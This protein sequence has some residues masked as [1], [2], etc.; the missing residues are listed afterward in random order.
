MAARGVLMVEPIGFASNPETKRD[1]AFQLAAAEGWRESV[2][3]R[4]R[5]EF[6]ELRDVLIERN[7]EVVSFAA[8]RDGSPDATFPNNWFSTHREGRVVLYPLKAENRRRERR[9]EIVAYLNARYDEII[10]LSAAEEEDRF[11]EGTG[12][13]VIDDRERLVY[14][15][16]SSRTHSDLVHEWCRLFDFKPVLFQSHDREGRAVYHTNVLLCLGSDFAVICLEAVDPPSRD[17]LHARLG[18]SGRELIEITLDQMH[19]FCGN[20]LELENSRG[21]RLVVGSSRADRA[22]T[23]A[24]RL[25]IQK[26]ADFVS[27]SLD[28]IE[29]HGGGSARCM[30]AE[31]N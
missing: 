9:P 15:S 18:Q 28:T 3:T 11:L 19:E 17:D 21:D 23:D 30:L 26:H 24:Q 25:T 13:L 22:F 29:K 8:E 10:D 4:A 16:E 12:S 7:V 14:A 6:R 1:N 2:E 27:V 20:M 5:A 31:L